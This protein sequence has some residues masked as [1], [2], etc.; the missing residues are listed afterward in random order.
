VTSSWAK[1]QSQGKEM[2]PH[3]NFTIDTGIQ[4]FFCNPKNR[5]Q[6][7]TNE[8]TNGRLRQYFPERSYLKP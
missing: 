8:N 4:I 6:H 1:R 5:W 2:A 7:G 3:A